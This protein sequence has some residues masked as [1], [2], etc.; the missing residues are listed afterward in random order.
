MC[1]SFHLYHYPDLLPILHVAI[2]PV[3]QRLDGYITALGVPC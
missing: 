3:S 1:Q 2:I